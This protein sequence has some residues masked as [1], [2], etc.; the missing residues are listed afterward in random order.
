MTELNFRSGP[1]G[2]NYLNGTQWTVE[3]P[4]CY[5]C[6]Q[7]SNAFFL[8]LHSNLMT[9]RKHPFLLQGCRVSVECLYVLGVLST[10]FRVCASEATLS[11]LLVSLLHFLKHTW[12]SNGSVTLRRVRIVSNSVYL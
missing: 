5:C 11:D 4:Q 6:V 2:D 7:K 9:L 12:F 10:I 3:E 8:N 1:T